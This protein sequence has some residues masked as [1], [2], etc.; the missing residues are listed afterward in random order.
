MPPKKAKAAN[1]PPL[2]D[3]TIAFAS[4]S[5]PAGEPLKGTKLEDLKAEITRCGGSYTSKISECTH[6]IASESQFNKKL[7][8]IS[9]ALNE[10][11]VKIVGYAWL[12]ESFKAKAP[13]SETDHLLRD[14]SNQASQTHGTSAKQ[15]TKDTTAT[16][17]KGNKKDAKSATTNGTVVKAEDDDEA[18]VSNTKKRKRNS[19]GSNESS[20]GHGGGKEMN[21]T[22]QL[23]MNI[24]LDH[25]LMSYHGSQYKVHIGDDSAIY[26]V[27]LNQS[28]AGENANKFYIIQ[29]LK[30]PQD[31]WYTWTRWGRKIMSSL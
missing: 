21:V 15:D 11:T 24:P 7:T 12:E 26:D 14:Q 29:L 4:S 28:N 27:T 23:D 13:V 19:A 25:V 20:K 30:T 18:D 31:T 6:L 16:K 5:I 8:K 3:F 17:S 1:S 22:K 2:K 10:S 9:E